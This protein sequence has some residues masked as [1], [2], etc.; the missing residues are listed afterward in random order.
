MRVGDQVQ[1][2]VLPSAA[3]FAQP[4]SEEDAVRLA[5]RG[6]PAA[7]DR[8]FELHGRRVYALCLRMTSNPAE[9]EDLAQETFLRVFRKIRTFRGDSA[10]STWLH[11]V[12][13]N[14]VL[15]QLRRKKLLMISLDEP[16]AP[17]QEDSSLAEELGSADASLANLPHRISLERAVSRL[18]R[19]HR[20]VFLL[21][22]VHG[23]KHREIARI[24]NCSVGNSKAI[25]HRAR[26]RLRDFLSDGLRDL[27]FACAAG[28]CHALC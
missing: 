8:L 21:H 24:L 12:A 14:V 11:R 2:G 7:F 9:A 4:L 22:D 10:F 23:Y 3:F 18:S 6:E 17:D 19:S 13:V 5:R 16:V 25:L 1:A 20:T 27:R 26:M 15:M 28:H